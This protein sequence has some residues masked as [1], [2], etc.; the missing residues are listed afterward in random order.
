MKNFFSIIFIANSFI[1]L[2]Q[3]D[4]QFTQYTYNMN[5]INPAYATGDKGHV[6]LGALYRT[7]WVNVEG[8]PQTITLFGHA[9]LRKN[10]DLGLT[11][12][13]DQIGGD[14]SET[15]ING[16]IAYRFNLS[17]N[18]RFS[19]GAKLGVT[20]YNADFTNSQLDSGGSSTD[21]LFSENINS[22]SLNIGAGAFLYT[23]KFYLGLSAPNLLPSKHRESTIATTANGKEEIHMYLT[24]GYV[25]YLNDSYKFKPS[26]LLKSV[27]GAPL[28]VDIS[29][30]LLI[31]NRF[32]VGTSYRLE[33]AISALFRYNITPNF[34]IG[35]AYDYTISDLNEFSQGSH[36][37]FLTYS[38]E[39]H[40]LIDCFPNRF[41]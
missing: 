9:S 12:V 30:S 39:V 25:F 18:L 35:Y 33:D 14:I 21:P 40:S 31:K 24:S 1:C 28:T 13:N 29:A 3:Q 6:A 8:A 22:T 37:F 19:L 27:T 32:E 41:F 38:F 7:Q 23:R 10:I 11:I 4:P 20:Q 5:I 16:D 26:F 36:E 2:A 17:R 15:N 34:K